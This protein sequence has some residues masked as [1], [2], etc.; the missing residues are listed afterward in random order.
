MSFEAPTAVAD[1]NDFIEVETLYGKLKSH[2]IKW[3]D[4]EKD[5]TDF[6]S[7]TSNIETGG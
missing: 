1:F 7:N 6:K 2:K 4:S 3:N 5:Q